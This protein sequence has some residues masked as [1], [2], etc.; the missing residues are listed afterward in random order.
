MAKLMMTKVCPVCGREFYWKTVENGKIIDIDLR[1]EAISKCPYCGAELDE[2]YHKIADRGTGDP[3]I[4]IVKKCPK[5]GF[6]IK[7]LKISKGNIIEFNEEAEN[8]MV[9]PVCG[10]LLI[11]EWHNLVV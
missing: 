9:C 4:T 2:N 1:V 8:L 7:W 3:V 5:C 10:T 11:T 6:E